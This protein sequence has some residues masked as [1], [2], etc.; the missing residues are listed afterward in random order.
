MLLGAILMFLAQL[1]TVSAD[2]IYLKR[3]GM[4]MRVVITGEI[5]TGIPLC[6]AF[7]RL[8]LSPALYGR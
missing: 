6:L 2:R 1:C 3:P 7:F 4:V 5:A 8:R